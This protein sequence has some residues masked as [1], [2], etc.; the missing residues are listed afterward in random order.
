MSHTAEQ[1]KKHVRVDVTVLALFAL[2]TL[3]HVTV[4]QMHL[5][6]TG[7][8]VIGLYAARIALVFYYFAYLT[9]GQAIINITLLLTAF[10]LGV[11]L[12]LPLFR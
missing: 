3:I 1:I 5:P 2:L 7:F 8:I 4:A 6:G 10:F 11:L 12:I 9:K